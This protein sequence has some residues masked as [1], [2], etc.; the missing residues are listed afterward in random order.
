M[1]HLLFLLRLMLSIFL[2]FCIHGLFNTY[3]NYVLCLFALE[4]K[5]DVFH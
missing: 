1:D 5:M 3:V 4:I 2:P